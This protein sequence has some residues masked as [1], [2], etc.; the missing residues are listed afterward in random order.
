MVAARP[1]ATHVGVVATTITLLTD[2][3]T[4][5]GFVGEMKGVLAT[6]APEAIVVDVSHDIAR[7]DLEQARLAVARY[8]RRFPPR[9]VH[10]CI[11]DPGVG[12]ARRSIAVE[13]DQRFLVG[14]DNGIL[15]PALVGGAARVVSL[16]IPP[17]ASA[18]FQGRDVFSPAA[19]ALAKGAALESLGPLVRDAIVHR[20]PEAH[21]LPDGAIRGEVIATDRFGNLITNLHASRGGTVEIAGEHIAIAR[22]YADVA[23]GELVAYVGSSGL[24]EIALRDGEAARILMARRGTPVVLRP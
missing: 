11:V 23:P 15:S 5:D 13:A 16:P 21:R 8:W 7:H 20:T 3:R 4:A 17:D 6:L 22:T 10:L 2:F 24:V 1:G 14:P 12:S 19:A 9:T 18:T